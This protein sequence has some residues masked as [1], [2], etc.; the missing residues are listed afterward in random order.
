MSARSDWK[1]A[2]L[3]VDR[4]LSKA[5]EFSIQ[6]GYDPA[7]PVIHFVS[8]ASHRVSQVLYLNGV[9]SLASGEEADQ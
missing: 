5:L 4:L 3:E 8:L 2:A 7:D 6:R 9:D 1:A